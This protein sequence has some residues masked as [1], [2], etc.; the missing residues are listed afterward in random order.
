M[1]NPFER[2]VLSMQEI[3]GLQQIQIKTFSIE[4]HQQGCFSE[5][6]PQEIQHSFL[7]HVAIHEQLIHNKVCLREI[8][9]AD[10]KNIR[11]GPAAQTGGLRIQEHRLP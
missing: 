3:P 4:C 1:R 11:P 8:A 7:F 5:I 6:F 9:E 10:H 2:I